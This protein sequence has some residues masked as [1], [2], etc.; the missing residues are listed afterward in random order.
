MNPIAARVNK[1]MRRGGMISATELDGKIIGSRFEALRGRPVADIK[2][3]GSSTATFPKKLANTLQC[4]EVKDAIWWNAEG[5]AFAMMP[6]NFTE[7]VLDKL[8]QGTK[9]ESLQRKM[10]RWGFER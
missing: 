8:F 6:E 5:T 9:L 7:K 10:K 1:A 4:E 2:D 3:R